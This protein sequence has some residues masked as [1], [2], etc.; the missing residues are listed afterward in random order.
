[1][2]AMAQCKAPL[3]AHAEVTFTERLQ[4]SNVGIG[5]DV[6][7]AVILYKAAIASGEASAPTSK[8]EK[9]SVELAITIKNCKGPFHV[10]L[11]HYIDD[12][13]S[14]MSQ[15]EFKA[16]IYKSRTAFTSYVFTGVFRAWDAISLKMWFGGFDRDLVR[17]AVTHLEQAL[18]TEMERLGLY[19][20]DMTPEEFGRIALSNWDKLYDAAVHPLLSI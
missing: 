19:K 18:F 15:R 2:W 7:W 4:M 6:T 13:V 8:N 9:Y 12:C 5:D 20:A 11:Q 1:M 10:A 14:G 16:F 17:N 3:S